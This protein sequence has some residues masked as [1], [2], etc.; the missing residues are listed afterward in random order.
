MANSLTNHR[1]S[2]S[3][4]LTKSDKL[5]EIPQVHLGTRFSVVVLLH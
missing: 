4:R 5:V 3:G 1:S 2:S